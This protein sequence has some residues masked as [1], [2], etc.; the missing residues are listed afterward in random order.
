MV[1]IYL[2]DADHEVNAAF[3][4]SDA[5]YLI[6]YFYP[7]FSKTEY[8]YLSRVKLVNLIDVDHGNKIARF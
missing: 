8:L 5:K 3:M 4:K 7:E 1:K 2:F 6:Y